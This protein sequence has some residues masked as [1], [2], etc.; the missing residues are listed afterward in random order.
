MSYHNGSVWPHDNALIAAGMARYGFRAEAARIFQ[1]AV[2]GLDLHRPQAPARAVLRL[3]AAPQPR[4]DLL[5]GRLRA[6]G[7][8][9]GGADLAAALLP[10][11]RLRPRERLRH[12]RPAGAARLHRRHRAAPAVARRR[13]PR[14]AARPRRRAGRRARARAAAVGSGRLRGAERSR[15]C[16][17]PAR[18]RRISAVRRRSAPKAKARHDRS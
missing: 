3:P 4:P 8:G 6:A 11:H 10:R 5:P 13:P 9:G 2:R 15:A 14:R 7:L 18:G 16:R 17:L 1:R 12:L